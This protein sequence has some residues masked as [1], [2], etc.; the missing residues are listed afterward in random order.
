MSNIVHVTGVNDYLAKIKGEQRVIVVDF[1]A[2]WCGP[3]K[4]LGVLLDQ[5]SQKYDQEILIL[6]IDVDEDGKLDPENQL[7]SIFQVKSLP[8]IC[9]VKDGQFQ[10]GEDYRIVG[11]NQNRLLWCLSRLTGQNM[12]AF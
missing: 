3:C 5:L 8:T 4:T 6:K 11:F 7:S 10:Q 2:S 12:T 1:S 9:F